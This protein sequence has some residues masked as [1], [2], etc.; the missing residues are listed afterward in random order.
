MHAERGDTITGGGKQLFFSTAA[1]TVII[2]ES[3]PANRNCF[4]PPTNVNVSLMF[5]RFAFTASASLSHSQTSGDTRK[6][7]HFLSFYFRTKERENPP[8][9]IS[10]S[11][12]TLPLTSSIHAL[13]DADASVLGNKKK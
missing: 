12:F 7:F 13:I 8:L 2:V 11:I 5:E 10:S 6:H 4:I 3:M 9:I 1:I